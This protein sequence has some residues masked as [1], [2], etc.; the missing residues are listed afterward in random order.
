M[1]IKSEFKDIGNLSLYEYLS[2]LDAEQFKLFYSVLV[3]YRARYKYFISK[4][5]LFNLCCELNQFCHEMDESFP[6]QYDDHEIMKSFFL[7]H[8]YYYM[9]TLPIDLIAR[10][11]TEYVNDH[12]D[13]LANIAKTIYETDIHAMVAYANRALGL[14]EPASILVSQIQ[15]YIKCFS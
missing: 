5:N 13:I 15:N 4:Q 11:F 6:D 10:L 2:K 9:D 12:A 14:N 8:P 1:T 3:H 7:A